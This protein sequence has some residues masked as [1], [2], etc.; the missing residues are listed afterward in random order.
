MIVLLCGHKTIQYLLVWFLHSPSK[1]KINNTCLLSSMHM[2][3]QLACFGG[4]TRISVLLEFVQDL[5]KMR[6]LF[7]FNQSSE[8]PTLSQCLRVLMNIMLLTLLMWTCFYVYRRCIH[9]YSHNYIKY[10]HILATQT[11]FNYLKMFR[12]YCMVYAF[13][14]MSD[15]SIAM[16]YLCYCRPHHNVARV[17][18][19]GLFV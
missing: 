4:K 16:H 2:M 9:I 3:P 18:T 13:S 10:I 11:V 1:L 7:L 14:G 17:F 8:E 6:N 15:I 5:E 19:C 12:E